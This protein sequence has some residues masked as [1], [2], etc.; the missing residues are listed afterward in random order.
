MEFQEQKHGA[1]TVIKPGG[2]L[3]REDAEAFRAR[4]EEA[5]ARSFG[6][7]VVDVSGVPFVDSVGLETLVEMT[8]QL[9]DSGHALKLCG[10]CGTLREVLDLTDLTSLFEYFED[11]NSAV[12]SYL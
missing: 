3:V 9:A 8:E 7:V 6:R 2:A 5:R 1:V 11:I 4:L 10:V 12:R